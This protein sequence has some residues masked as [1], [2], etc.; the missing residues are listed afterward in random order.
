MEETNSDTLPHCTVDGKV[1]NFVHL[2][3]TYGVS[4]ALIPLAP[5]PWTAI[6]GRALRRKGEGGQCISDPETLGS[7][8]RYCLP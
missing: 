2:P 7:L 5:D 8:T 3:E 1:S 4:P 6:L